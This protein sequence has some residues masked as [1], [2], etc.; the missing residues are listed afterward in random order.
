MDL[1]DYREKIDAIDDQLI[2]L[3][4]ER[5][6]LAAEIARY[7]EEHHIGTM[8]KSRERSILSRISQQA[9]PGLDSYARILF[10]TIFDLSRAYQNRLRTHDSALA[11]KIETALANTPQLFPTKGLV[12]CQGIE[13]A[14][15]QHACDKLFSFA[16]ILYFKTFEGVF[17]AVEQ[18]LCEYGIL[19]IEN[20]SYG[21]VNAVYDLMRH[22]NFHIVR[23]LKLKIDH[24][25]LTK[26]KK[27]LSD[28][29]EIYSHEQAIGQCSRFLKQHPEIKITVCENTAVAAKMVADSERQ[30]IAAISSQDC[31]ELYGL[32]VLSDQIQ[33]SDS[34]FTR[35]ICISKELQI[36][37]GS[38]KISLMLSLPHRPGALYAFISKI[39]ALGLNVSKLESRP[40]P[41]KDFEFLFYFD[42]DASV[43]SP[44]V[45]QF[46][47]ELSEQPELFMFLGNYSEA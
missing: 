10:S 16:N 41:G 44:E 23:S 36:F 20:S 21:S 7:K 1:N 40:I 15:S 5:M 43:L 26:G 9:D 3:F 33:N 8:V 34:N 14:Y 4:N 45:I 38:N 37:P 42:I 47:S 39:T 2:G 11:K 25:L 30:D 19:P 46:L 22:F 29:R 13:G 35:F 32:S 18:G 28:I 27:T 31:A 6:Q 17:Q 24:A 12:A